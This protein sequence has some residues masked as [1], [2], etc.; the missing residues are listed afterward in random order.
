MEGPRN[1]T[2]TPSQN[3]QCPG[4]KLRHLSNTSQKSYQVSQLVQFINSISKDSV[5][6]PAYTI[7]WTQ[8]AITKEVKQW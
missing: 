6:N 3:G 7:A 4:W 5:N 1:I 2:K 8:T